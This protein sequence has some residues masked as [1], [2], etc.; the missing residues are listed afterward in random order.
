L[1]DGNFAECADGCSFG[2]GLLEVPNAFGV[3]LGA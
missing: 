2:N 1:G 3:L